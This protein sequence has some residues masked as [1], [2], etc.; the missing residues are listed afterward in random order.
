[1]SGY[2]LPPGMSHAPGDGPEDAA[3]CH[4]WEATDRPEKVFTEITGMLIDDPTQLERLYEESEQYRKAIDKDFELMFWGP[5]E[6]WQQPDEDEED[7]HD[8]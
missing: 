2:N 8:G 4:Y 1:M 6:S 7:E 5:P 3:W